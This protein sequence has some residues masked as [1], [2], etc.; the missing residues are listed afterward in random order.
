[1]EENNVWPSLYELAQARGL[2]RVSSQPQGWLAYLTPSGRWSGNMWWLAVVTDA[3]VRQQQCALFLLAPDLPFARPTNRR[4]GAQ[5]PNSQVTTALRESIM[6]P[7][8][9]I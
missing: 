4:S 6:Q 9:G 1:M 5:L 3:T 7:N 8:G 2:A